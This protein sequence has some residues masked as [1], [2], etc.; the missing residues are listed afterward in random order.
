MPDLRGSVGDKGTNAVHD[1]AL[2]QAM[3]RV[4]KNAKGVE[5]FGNYT[6]SYDAATKT[7]II[8]FQTDQKLIAAP[9]AKLDPA[10][11][12][13]LDKTGLVDKNSAT[14]KALNQALPAAHKDMVIMAGSR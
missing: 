2:V 1:V 8:A 4:V 6:G 9:G 13:K 10:A 5:Y 3:L 7:A 14:L 11:A 12:A